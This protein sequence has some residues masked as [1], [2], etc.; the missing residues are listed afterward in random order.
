MIRVF[1]MKSPGLRG[2]MYGAG[3]RVCDQNHNQ[4]L[5]SAGL[6]LPS[7][8]GGT[9]YRILGAELPENCEHQRPLLG[10]DLLLATTRVR[11]AYYWQTISICCRNWRC[12]CLTTKRLPQRTADDIFNQTVASSE[13]GRRERCWHYCLS[14]RVYGL[15]YSKLMRTSTASFAETQF[16]PQ[17]WRFLIKSGFQKR[18]FDCSIQKS[19]VRHFEPQT[20]HSIPSISAD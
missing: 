11:K 15:H 9:N 4:S 18:C 10:M 19:T 7:L 16:T 2:I 17:C 6:E 12:L 8:A 13:A 5:V 20:L 3:H 1:L 14:D